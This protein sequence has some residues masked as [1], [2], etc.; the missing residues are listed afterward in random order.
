DLPPSRSVYV[1]CE[2][3]DVDEPRRECIARCVRPIENRC[4][5]RRVTAPVGAH[6]PAPQHAARLVDW[7]REDLRMERRIGR[8]TCAEAFL[9]E[10]ER[11][12]AFQ[13][14][15]SDHCNAYP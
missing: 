3:G 9:R 15:K 1:S 13:C 12:G 4:A 11:T 2:P 7:N 10:P 8:K 14:Q 6:I 5:R